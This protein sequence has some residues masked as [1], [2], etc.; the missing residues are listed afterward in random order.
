M[1]FFSAFLGARQSTISES[2]WQ[3]AVGLLWDIMP[4]KRPIWT[5]NAGSPNNSHSTIPLISEAKPITS[6]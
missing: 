6:E 2:D 4:G 3:E 5:V 1:L